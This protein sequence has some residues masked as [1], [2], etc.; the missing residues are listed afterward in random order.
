[1]HKRRRA[2]SNTLRGVT[3]GARLATKFLTSGQQQ[4]LEAKS[5]NIRQIVRNMDSILRRTLVKIIEIRTSVS[6]GL[7]NSLPD[8]VQVAQSHLEPSVLNLTLATYSL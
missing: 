3:L 1:M 5:V 6:G 4:A 7:W 2:F 8:P